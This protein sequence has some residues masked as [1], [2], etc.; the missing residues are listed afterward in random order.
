MRVRLSQPLLAWIVLILVVLS[1]L[2]LRLVSPGQNA[3]AFTTD[4]TRLYLPVIL[5]NYQPTIYL[6]VIARSFPVVPT[7]F[8]VE[9]SPGAIL[10]V[11]PRAREARM[12]WAR[13]SAIRWSDVEAV[14]QQRSWAAL[15]ET[16][17]RIAALSS[18]GLIPIVSV[19]GTPLWA[20]KPGA[21][22]ARCGPIREES[23]DAFA[24]F[25]TDLVRRYSVP[26]YN[27]KYWEMGNEPDVAPG[28]VDPNSV[29]GC[30]GD[31]NDPY[32][33]GGYYAEMLKRVYPAIKRADPEAQ[34]LIGGLLL[35]CDPTYAYPDGRD[36]LPG[37]FLE[38]IL[39]NGGAA[40]FDIMAYHAYTYYD[41]HSPAW[42]L[43]TSNWEHRGGTV[44]GKLHFIRGVMAQH[45]VNK[46][47]M[48]NEGGLL[49]YQ[50][51]DCEGLEEAKSNYAVRLYA[52]SITNHLIGSLWYTLDGPGWQNGGLLD[53]AQNPR[54]AFH[55]VQFLAS[56]LSG[57]TPIG[58][59]LQ[60]TMEQHTFR[61]RGMIYRLY[62][63]NGPETV[64][65]PLPPGA[66]VYNRLG[67]D[68]TPAAPAINVTFEPVIIEST[69]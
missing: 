10:T 58:S 56:R 51:I 15:T 37:R 2:G 38:G 55:T 8:G 52:R 28:L 53:P 17:Q 69:Q 43:T 40:G 25:M 68:I 49:C 7:I 57:A 22:Q 12:S 67:Q 41:R 1:P 65:V 21:G 34:V 32:Y 30:W 47:I 13:Y 48:M 9:I 18:N 4:S 6:P 64:A 23:L 54:P 14:Q 20:Q 42:D 29:Y 63:V 24:S 27:V 59:G 39:R 26:P 3:L 60:G 31:P 62:W 61:N 50:S 5:R 66:R 36:C 44:I 45:G 35:D 19:Q 11:A 46:P 16:E 33:G